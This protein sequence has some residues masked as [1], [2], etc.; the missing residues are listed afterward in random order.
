MGEFQISFERT[1]LGEVVA[2]AGG[3]IAHQGD[4][5]NTVRWLCYSLDGRKRH[6][7]VWFLSSEM[8]GREQVITGI[9]AE[10]VK[11]S[12]RACPALPV[13]LLPVSFNN[14]IWLGMP[15]ATVTSMF[16]APPGT[17]G[18][19]SGYRYEHKGD[20]TCKPNGFDVLNSLQWRTVGGGVES[21]SAGQV[22]SC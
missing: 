6:Q 21:I 11:Q 15:A 8:G 19:W 20:G 13:T 3:V 2:A 9:I 10:V 4:A 16:A 14:G 1:Q 22:S 17:L 5:G 7:Q 12:N 18:S